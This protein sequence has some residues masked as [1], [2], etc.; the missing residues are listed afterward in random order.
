MTKPHTT[1]QL[2]RAARQAADL[3][4]AE[5]AAA[6]DSTQ[7]AISEIETGKRKPTLDMLRRLA[8]PLG[9]HGRD[10]IGD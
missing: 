9:C 8:V 10:L 3:T 4:Q 1:G 7:N 6:A 5:L 2:I